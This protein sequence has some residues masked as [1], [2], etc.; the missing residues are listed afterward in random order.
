VKE[1]DTLYSIA[2]QYGIKRYDLARYNRLNGTKILEK[3]DR[4]FI[5]RVLSAIKVSSSRRTGMVP[6]EV[7]FEIDT[8]TRDRIRSYRWELGNGKVSAK[9]S[10]SVRYDEKGDYYV[11]LTVVDENGN[12]ITS[13]TIHVVARKL[14]HISFNA[15]RY[16]VQNVGD[17]VGLNTEVI[18]N[19]NNRIEFDY[20]TK[21]TQNPALLEQ[22]GTTDEFEVIR[23]GYSKITFN[24]AGKYEHTANF[25]VSPVAAKH[26]PEPDAE[27]YKTQFR[28]GNNGNCGPSCIAMAI[29]WAKGSDVDVSY[30]R[31]LIGMPYEEGKIGFSHMT[32]VFDR[33]KVS[34]TY[35]NVYKPD[36]IRRVIDQGKI[37]IILLDTGNITP[38][39]GNPQ[40][41]F[42]GRYY[43]DTVGHYIIIK[44]YSLDNQYFIAYDPIPSDW[45]RN[46]LRYGDGESMIGKNRFYPVQEVMNAVKVK[47]H[48][49]LSVA[50]D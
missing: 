22:I 14:A 29:Y 3:G 5:P 10:P 31:K 8:D 43:R 2:M 16:F 47:T 4:I 46:R 50:Q 37:A 25:F 38:T 42:V 44:G 19:L 36:D 28:T 24:V 21:I 32:N 34:W 33:Y 26:A 7:R 15:P 1:G 13:N 45:F 40:T 20:A 35:E 12:S 18:D 6:F 30:I 11:N 49:F 41:N 23:P 48:S 9:K 17:R 27:W 39:K